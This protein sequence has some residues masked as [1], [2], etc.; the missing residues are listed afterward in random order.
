M[1]YLDYA[2]TT[3]MKFAPVEKSELKN[4]HSPHAVG[5]NSYKAIEQAR[6]DIKRAVGCK[7]GIVLFVGNATSLIASVMS[8]IKNKN[9]FIYCN[10]YE[11]EA[12]YD[13]AD[14]REMYLTYENNLIE[15]DE[16]D[17]VCHMLMNNI[18]GT[19]FDLKKI[20]KKNKFKK[21]FLFADC[22]AAIGHMEF[23]KDFESICDVWVCSAHKFYGPQNSGILWLSDRFASRFNIKSEKDL[24]IGTLPVFNILATRDAFVKYQNPK[25]IQESQERFKNYWL[26]LSELLDSYDIKHK[27]ISSIECPEYNWIKWADNYAINAI[28]FENINA[29][30]LAAYLSSKEIYIGVGHS[31][32]AEDS[33]Y[34]VLRAFGLTEQEAQNTIRVS[35]GE[36]TNENDIVEL[37]NEIYN[38]KKKFLL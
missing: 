27:R 14:M 8:K 38:Y 26:I 23:P 1:V 30:A 20:S 28:C 12:I 15:I 13:W 21:A 3:P 22:T 5:I 10:P 2:A 9:G 17:I 29:D 11:H 33:D 36:D 24:S 4:S 7:S 32:C 6:E 25:Y 16:N 18:T 37:V 34:R 35:F 31:A 19:T